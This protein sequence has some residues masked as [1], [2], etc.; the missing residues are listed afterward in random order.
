MNS[1]LSLPSEPIKRLTVADVSPANRL[2]TSFSA[3]GFQMEQVRRDRDIAIYKQT[4]A[5]G[6]VRYEV[7][8]IQVHPEAEIFGRVYPIRESLPPSEQWGNLGW[9]FCSLEAAEKKFKNMA[10]A[11]KARNKETL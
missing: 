9:T 11:Y 1:P 2:S 5:F 10:R 3:F 6:I 4:S 8:V 7:I